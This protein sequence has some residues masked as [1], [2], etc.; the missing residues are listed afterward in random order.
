MIT[1]LIMIFLFASSALAENVLYSQ[2][3]ETG[4]ELGFFTDANSMAQIT[5]AFGSD[6]NATKALNLK[7]SGAFLDAAKNIDISGSVIEFDFLPRNITEDGFV[8]FSILSEDNLAQI[9]VLSISGEALC[10][11]GQEILQSVHIDWYRIKL[12]VGE[13]TMCLFLNNRQKGETIPHIDGFDLKKSTLRFAVSGANGKNCIYIDNI[14]VF[15]PMDGEI[16]IENCDFL[17]YECSVEEILPGE[18]EASISFFN[19]DKKQT[20]KS[21]R[22]LVG[23]FDK[24]DKCH[25]VASKLVAVNGGECVTLSQPITVPKNAGNYEIK[26]FGWDDKMEPYIT[27]D[28]LK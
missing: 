24:K 11:M 4:D 7:G 13:D 27:L 14:N 10:F 6:A 18:I 20:T 2:D 19:Y 12:I 21:L 15:K 5:A 28:I 17:R 8:V 23:L 25:V 3:F 9:P 22:I 26:V 16:L 1:T